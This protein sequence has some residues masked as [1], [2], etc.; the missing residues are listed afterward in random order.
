MH[1]LVLCSNYEAGVTRTKNAYTS[2]TLNPPYKPDNNEA[3]RKFVVLHPRPTRNLTGRRK[4]LVWK[5]LW[6]VIKNHEGGTCDCFCRD[7]KENDP[8]PENIQ[9][10]LDW[11]QSKRYLVPF[12]IEDKWQWPLPRYRLNWKVLERNL[13]V[14]PPSEL[15]PLSPEEFAK[16]E[17]AK[18]FERIKRW[19]QAIAKKQE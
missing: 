11:L 12:E 15:N 17:M 3:Y 16:T 2:K 6:K 18:V 5:I 1:A 14:Y 7:F 8:E 10:T 4:P 9:R 13:G 19:K